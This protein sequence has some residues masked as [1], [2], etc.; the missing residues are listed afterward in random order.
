MITTVTLATTLLIAARVLDAS[1]QTAIDDAA[2]A[3]YSTADVLIRSEVAGGGAQ[4]ADSALGGAGGQLDPAAITAIEKLTDVATV[5]TY[6]RA[7]AAAQ[8]G[9]V[10]RGIALESLPADTGLVWQR[11][12]D[13]RSPTS[14]SEIALTA[15]TLDA[16]AIGVGDRVAIGHPGVGRA[17][18]TVVGVVDTRGAADYSGA[19]GVVTEPVAQSLAATSAPNV[20]AIRLR[21]GVSRDAAVDAINATSPGGFAQTTRDL[22]SA[23]ADAQ[24]DRA[25]GISAAVTA[26]SLLAVLVSA[27]VLAAVTTTS[28]SARRRT[29]ALI[30]SIGATRGQT[31][32]QVLTEVVC[33]G[34]LGLAIGLMCGIGLARLALPAVGVLPGLPDVPGSAFTL[35]VV[36]L[37]IA[38]GACAVLT[39]FA[40]I[41]PAWHAVRVPPAAALEDSPHAAGRRGLAFS[42]AASVAVLVLAAAAL[43]LV[44]T[45]IGSVVA[46]TTLLLVAGILVL[47]PALVAVAWVVGRL[48]RPVPRL[49]A[50]EIA[51]DPRR[52]VSEGVA[53]TVAVTLVAMTWVGLASIGATVS[54][55]LDASAEP[56]LTVGAPT[57]TG[58]IP[59]QTIASIADLDGI[60]QVTEVPYGTDVRLTGRDGDRRVAVSVGTAALTTENLEAALPGGAPVALRDDTVYLPRAETPTFSTTSTVTATGPAGTV[61]DLRVVYVDDLAVPSLL[62]PTVMERITDRT[63]V[64]SLW[65]TLSPRAD[66]GRVLDAVS[67]QAVLGGPLPVSGPAVLDQQADSAL[68]A[69]R[70]TATALLAVAVAV[71]IIGAATTAALSVTE[72]RREH[73]LIRA[74]GLPARDLRRVVALRLAL[75]SLTSGAVGGILGAVIGQAAARA[76]AHALEV[77]PVASTPWIAVVV[78]VLVIA[79]LA[80]IATTGPAERAALVSPARALTP[81]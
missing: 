14:G 20:A 49:A 43:G 37:L 10:T 32:L 28:I 1:T 5:G 42:V 9:D 11:W 62:T 51:R 6:T 17:Q 48:P 77:D 70:A 3:P 50:A 16:L 59:A 58:V 13:G 56:D 46:G 7:R 71:A 78:V 39:F 57:G 29:T 30:R 22:A 34:L 15:A 44:D 60:E 24:G 80:Q 47:R 36:D 55:R 35:D 61:K 67:G 79:A 73:A 23:Q 12:T 68:S 72:Q 19:Y 21:P 69:A 65:L 4:S 31:A 2:G 26:L 54:Q 25:A 41:V 8:V 74:L 66:R 53:L 52:A 76:V 81:A 33:V 75:I 45:G 64:R 18:F 63:E 38:L 40:V 27:L